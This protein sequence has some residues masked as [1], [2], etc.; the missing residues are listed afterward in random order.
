MKSKIENPFTFVRE[1]KE[2]GINIFRNIFQINSSEQRK[3][4]EARNFDVL[5][6]NIFEEI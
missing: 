4:Q 5:L 6:K 2:G 3:S 1:I